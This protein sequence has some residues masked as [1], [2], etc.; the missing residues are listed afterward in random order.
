MLELLTCPRGH[1]WESPAQGDAQR[2][3]PE[4]GAPAEGLP[5]PDLAPTVPLIPPPREP[6]PIETQGHPVVPGYEVLEELDRGPTGVRRFRARQSLLGRQVLLEVVLAREDATQRAWSSLRS[7]AGLLGKLS[8]PNIVPIHDAGERDRQLFYNVVEYV[9]GGTLAAQEELLPIPQVLHLVETLAQAVE[10]AHTLAVTHRHLE[11]AKVLLQ[12]VG[13]TKG[14]GAHSLEAGGYVPRITGFG[15]PRRPI[16]GDP[17]DAELYHDAGFMSPEQAWGRSKELGP[18]TDTYGLGGILYWLLTGRAPFRGP[19]LGDVIDAVQTAALVPP[20]SIR[21]VSADLEWVC[22][23]ALARQPKRRYATAAALAE[24]LRRVAQGLPP[25]G[26]QE[27]VFARVSRWMRR[28]P[29]VTA[30][31]LTNVILLGVWLFRKA[32]SRGPGGASS[33]TRRT[34]EMEVDHL[35]QQ[36]NGLREELAQAKQR[37]RLAENRWKLDRVVQALAA[38]QRAQAAVLLDSWGESERHFEWHYLKAQSE[39]RRKSLLLATNGSQSGVTVDPASGRTVVVAEEMEEGGRRFG[40]L[41]VY[42]L[43][44]PRYVQAVPIPAGTVEALALAPDGSALGLLAV[45]RDTEVLVHAM[46]K[47]T[48]E[49]E[50]VLRNVIL[51]KVFPGNRLSGLA[52]NRDSQRLAVASR[53]GQIHLFDRRMPDAIGRSFGQ[54]VVVGSDKMRTHLAFSPDGTVLA[55]YKTGTPVVQRWNVQLGVATQALRGTVNALAMA[56]HPTGT[57]AVARTDGTIYFH[58]Q[59]FVQEFDKIEDAGKEIRQLAFSPDGERLAAAAEGVVRVWGRQGGSWRD[60]L[61]LPANGSVGLAFTAN[62]KGLV[63]CSGQVTM[64]WGVTE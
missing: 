53:Q 22:L 4:C 40:R 55:S 39:G 52:W 60:V 16:E 12:Y 35:H 61:T 8:H 41:L 54:R 10:Y 3:C 37:E 19:T 23:K 44:N 30:L 48:P 29:A 57:L 42:H 59:Q 1:Y 25:A 11:P 36:V 38:N 28:H 13:E 43:P 33:Q 56:Y 49:E 2:L 21:N 51:R 50:A 17:T 18:T 27:G 24:D 45:D 20:S 14:E 34:T 32:D 63:T 7:E 6:P 62:G 58:G 5:G 15:L 26:R 9:P 46:V 47:R 64:V 31:L